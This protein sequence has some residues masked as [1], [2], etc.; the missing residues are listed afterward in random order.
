LSEN[1][2]IG[3]RLTQQLTSRIAN[4]QYFNNLYRKSVMNA[5]IYFKYTLFN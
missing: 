1:I 4:D 3:A 2:Q 5:Q